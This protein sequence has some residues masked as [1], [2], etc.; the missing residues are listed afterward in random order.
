MCAGFL[1]LYCTGPLY[2]SIYL[3]CSEGSA[4]ALPH[5]KILS[6]L[7]RWYSTSSLSK[8]IMIPSLVPPPVLQHSHNLC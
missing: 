4:L 3:P 7:T 6:I 2:L 8:P 5:D 1:Y